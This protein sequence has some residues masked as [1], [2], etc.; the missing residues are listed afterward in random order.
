MRL[1]VSPDGKR[2]DE[3]KIVSTPKDFDE[4]VSLF[5]KLAQEL[6]GGSK[7]NAV[8][9]GIAGPLDKERTMLVNSPNISGWVKKPLRK[10][11]AKVINAPV[12]L[13]NDAALVGLGEA[14]TGAGKGYGIVAYI[15]VSTGV[16]GARIVEGNI[17]KNSMGFEPG[18]QIIDVTGSLCPSCRIPG[19]LEGSIS[20]RALEERYNKKPFEITDSQI[21]EE[22][23]RI[24]AHGLNNTI[25]H[26]SPDIVVLGGSMMVKEP[27]ISIG[28]VRFH[29]K[30]ILKIFP[31]PPRV[32]KAVLGD[33]GGLH[34]ALALIRQKVE[35]G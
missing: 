15:T 1:A 27:G 2:F 18:H 7:I 9:G 35:R 26:W 11:L 17:D 5:A 19:H 30:E 31:A 24:L 25:V 29:L 16:G 10:E 34:G 32:E 14:V 6:S 28:R 21:W 23:A 22:E 12:Y 4:G 3:P 20:G 33:T 13:E 8:A